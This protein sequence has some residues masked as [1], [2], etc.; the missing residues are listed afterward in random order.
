MINIKS[1]V[2]GIFPGFITNTKSNLDSKDKLQSDEAKNKPI[3]V[4]VIPTKS[5]KAA[6]LRDWVAA[7]LLIG[8]A[9][10]TINDRF[11]KP[12]DLSDLD[13]MINI[14]KKFDSNQDGH[15][16]KDELDTMT[17]F[18]NQVKK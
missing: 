7:G 18:I 16:S 17:K 14:I 3:E 15:L 4:I 13:R 8:F 10:L 12:K 5:T 2:S 9:G 6:V 11:I 1:I